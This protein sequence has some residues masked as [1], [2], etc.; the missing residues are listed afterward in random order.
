[1]CSHAKR[2]QNIGTST[3]NGSPLELCERMAL[4]ARDVVRPVP[5]GSSWLL[6]CL[7]ERSS[8]QD[9][10][11]NNIVEIQLMALD[12]SS[13]RHHFVFGLEEHKRIVRLE[14]H[15]D[16]EALVR[17]SSALWNLKTPPFADSAIRLK[18]HISIVTNQST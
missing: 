7:S 11:G 8:E 5:D 14:S 9:S 1:V 12:V 16:A 18:G 15:L 2:T 13:R 10:L 17:P 4:A 6:R 3:G